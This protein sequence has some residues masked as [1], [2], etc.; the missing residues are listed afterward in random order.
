MFDRS[1]YSIAQRSYTI[2][3]ALDYRPETE[4]HMVEV[5]L[6]LSPGNPKQQSAKQM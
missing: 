5:K 4:A 1:G 6:L 3:L 2:L